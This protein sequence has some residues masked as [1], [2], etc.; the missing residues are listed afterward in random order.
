MAKRRL[1][2]TEKKE[3]QTKKEHSRQTFEKL[4]TNASTKRRTLVF[5]KLSNFEEKIRWYSS[6]LNYRTQKV[7]QN[8]FKIMGFQR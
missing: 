3:N 7:L 1:K 5:L 2:S 8:R 4:L 6:F